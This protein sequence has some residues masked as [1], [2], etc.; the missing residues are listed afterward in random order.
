MKPNVTVYRDLPWYYA[1][2]LD[3]R[4]EDGI[5]KAFPKR[6][7]SDAAHETILKAFRRWGGKYVRWNGRDWYE[8]ALD[9]PSGSSTRT[10]VDVKRAYEELQK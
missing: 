6:L 5:V 7:L 2:L 3:W 9:K 10:A 1:E 8:V 4:V